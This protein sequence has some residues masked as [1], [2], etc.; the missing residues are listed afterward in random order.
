MQDD[1]IET[2]ETLPVSIDDIRRAA[3]RLA[4][5]A[6]RTPVMTGQSFDEAAGQ[7]VWFKCEQFQRAGAFKFRG[8]YNRIATLAP[9]QR[10]RGVIAFS[11]G[12]HA[13]AVALVARLFSIPAVICM[14]HRCADGKN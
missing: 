8:A 7:S 12:N 14:P 1:R 5:K 13:Q 4:G 2:P 6:H 10:Q 11:S 9:D 3:E